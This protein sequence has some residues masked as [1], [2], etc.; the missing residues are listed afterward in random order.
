MPLNLIKYLKNNIS[1]NVRQNDCLPY[2]NKTHL[3]YIIHLYVFFCVHVWKK[4]MIKN[5]LCY[6]ER[7]SAAA[8]NRSNKTTN[9]LYIV[10]K[11]KGLQTRRRGSVIHFLFFIFF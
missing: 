7:E 9:S 6:D 4:N 2:N 3:K 10:H 11:P 8:E 5:I 1:I